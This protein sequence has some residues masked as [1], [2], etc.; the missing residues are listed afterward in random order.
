MGDKQVPRC[1]STRSPQLIIPFAFF[2]GTGTNKAA[3][4]PNKAVY[5]LTVVVS[6]HP[7]ITSHIPS[8]FQPQS[9][10]SVTQ[11]HFRDKGQTPP[12]APSKDVAVS[13]ILHFIGI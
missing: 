12:F 11:V 1:F 13:I 9:C 2:G 10:M 8:Y 3:I 4:V 5:Q 6:S 7:L